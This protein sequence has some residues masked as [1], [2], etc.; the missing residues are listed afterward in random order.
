MN[1]TTYSISQIAVVTGGQL[2]LNCPEQSEIR[3][4]L[5]DSRRVLQSESAL[6][7]AIKG[8]RH[9]G[10]KFIADLFNQGVRN[11]I[12]SELNDDFKDLNANFIFV[13][14]ALKA[15]QRL[16]AHHRQHFNYN[17]IGITGSNGKT[18][19]KEWLYQLLRADLNI[20]RSPKSYNSQIGVPISVW[21]MQEENQLAI[22]EAG[23]SMPGEMKK[24]EA[25]IH[26]TVGIFTNIGSAHDENFSSE[27]EKVHEKL[28]LFSGVKTLIYNKDYTT[29]QESVN[30]FSFR[31]KDIKIFSWSR[32]SRADL[33]VGR[34]TK[35]NDDTEIQ[36]VFENE[37][38]NI[39]IPF[40]DDASVE[41]AI[42]C[43]SLMLVM[44]YDQT[45]I[46][47][48]MH[49]L[50]PV[51]MRLEMKTGI[52]N[53]SVINDSYN[54]DI[55]SLTIALDFLNQQKQHE[56]KTL[57]LSDIL[58]S[59][60]NEEALYKEVG[61]LL[62][63]KGITSLIGIGPAISRQE[64]YFSMEKKFFRSTDEFLRDFSPSDF[65]DETILLKGARLF[66]F[67]KISK[68]LQQKAHETVLE[69]NLNSLIH[70]LNYYRSRLKPHTKIMAM[71]KATSY[72]SGSFEVANILQFHHVDYLAV[73]YSD[74][75]VELRK[76][77]ITLP[78]MVMNP[79]VMNFEMMIKNR[80]EPEIY[81]FRQLNQLAEVLKKHQGEPFK[82]HLK[83]DT[84]MHRLGFEER[85]INELVVRLNNNKHLHIQ[86]VFSHLAGSDEAEHDGFTKLQVDRFKKMSDEILS[87]F[88]Y[89][90]MR[91]ML[92]SSGILRFSEAQFEMV[93][94]GIGLYGFAATPN[95]QNHLEQVATLKTTISQIKNVAANET[96]G[97][98]RKGKLKRDSIVA[99]VAIGYADGISRRLSNGVGKMMVNGKL[100]PIVGNVC[101][102]MCMLDITDI[103][104]KEGD[105]V[106]VFG[107]EYS[108]TEMSKATGTIPYEILVNVSQR[109]KR[110]YF[111]E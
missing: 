101:M 47:E 106:I 91:H 18:I 24:L 104:A 4:L 80:L 107:S 82:I 76:T 36:A 19:V 60:K 12:V 3:D 88:N 100:A 94:L 26:P 81:N 30:D 16:A 9:D 45:I 92:N 75:G 42:N 93:R 99:T 25:I 89:P 27:K 83:L 102:D 61:D 2:I 48:R 14:D 103:P 108:V 50:S 56:N 21:E 39:T 34:V 58:Q 51:A 54:S 59:G 65:R 32:K 28:E 38:I 10:H 110:V 20:V 17:V 98:S 37:F 66:G 52:N 70:N 31:E 95:E 23:I 64:N 84:G 49:M 1:E 77:G 63:A 29:I 44:G 40:I 79:E 5:T 35:S 111:H 8:E 62:K 109:V 71:V 74:E 90:I 86:S 7:F 55:G 46:Q 105:E 85:E 97:Y 69:I 87:N 67:E 57:I 73:A 96:I 6:F 15:M 41:N 11:F 68:V 43:W 53:C 72:G 33:Q 22:F 78:I 13:D